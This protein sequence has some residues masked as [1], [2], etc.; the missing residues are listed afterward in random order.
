MVNNWIRL[1]IVAL[2]W[3]WLLSA[4]P[5]PDLASRVTALEQRMRLL[6]P[7]FHSA[8]LPTDLDRRI[9]ALE[10]KMDSLLSARQPP[11]QP[12]AEPPAMP[13]PVSLSGDPAK[14][15]GGETR[16]PVAGYMD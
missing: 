15:G 8:G 12:A 9:L 11:S 10:E 16:L 3:H 14:Q 6:D 1:L 5:T 4:Q 2:P 13:Q 7:A